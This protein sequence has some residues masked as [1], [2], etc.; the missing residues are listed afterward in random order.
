MKF[1]LNLWTS[2]KVVAF[3]MMIAY[4]SFDAEKAYFWIGIFIYLISTG[5][6]NIEDKLGI[7]SNSIS[8]SWK[9][10]K[11]KNKDEDERKTNV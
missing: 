9:K 6:K 8:F 4:F 2:W 3:C 11:V 7:E 10:T 5:F 1:K